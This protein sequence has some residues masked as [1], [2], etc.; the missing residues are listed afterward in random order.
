MKKI[1]LIILSFTIAQ[2]CIAQQSDINVRYQ[3]QREELLERHEKNRN[4]MLKRYEEKRQ[5]L[6]EEYEAFRRNIRVR[7]GEDEP[8]ESTRKEWVEY[9]EDLSSRSIV[10]FE[11]GEVTIE[12]IADSTVNDKSI[13]KML[14]KATEDLMASK[15]KNIDFKSEVI[16]QTEIC[17][18]PI[19][20]GQLDLNRQKDPEKI[21]EN[22]DT[23]NGRKRKVSIHLELVPDH[24]RIRAAK[25][26]EIIHS[27]ATRFNISEPLIYAIIEQE[28][29][30]NPK[31]RS[32]ANAYGLMQIVP[33][34]GGL[35]ANIYVHGR[36][37]KPEPEYLYDP[38]NNI[39]L[40]A[41][42]L[43]KQL[44]VYFKDVTDPRCRTLCAIAAYNTGQGNVYYVF[45]GKRKPDGAANKINKYS[46]ESL[47]D[48]LRKNLT[49]SETRNYIQSVI[50]KMEKY[51][52]Y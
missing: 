10:D 42:Y 39:E 6:M 35:D 11:N 3:K 16:K 47:F 25:Y 30:F 7:W 50:S 29:F 4:R 18:A 5:K 48:H 21:T 46:Y 44:K 23:E 2:I 28:S 19:L 8:L 41:G 38:Y 33:E 31:A 52:V 37:E 45:T 27:H 43:Q 40:G 13:D 14:E 49:H 1:T 26:Q 34:S 22:N 32:I 24:I 17:P 20:E 15:G 36:H 51:K 12:V 9:S